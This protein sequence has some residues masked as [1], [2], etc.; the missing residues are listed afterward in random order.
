MENSTESHYVALP[1]GV[2]WH[3]LN[4]DVLISDF[5]Q[6]VASKLITNENTLA[7]NSVNV[8][9]AIYRFRRNW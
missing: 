5:G 4:E 2:A 7:V 6:N 1:F 8:T 3:W 9:D